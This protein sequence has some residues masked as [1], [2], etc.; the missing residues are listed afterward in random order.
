MP[1]AIRRR[2][3]SLWVHITMKK[4]IIRIG[5]VVVVLVLLAAAVVFFSLNSIVKK[6]VE[7]LG[8][9]MTKVEVRLGSAEISPFSGSGK[10]SKLFV[11]NPEGYKTPSAMEMGSIK[12]GVKVSSIMSDTIVV[13]EINIQAPDITLEG[14]LTGASNLKKILDNLDSS[15]AADEKQKN[16][17]PAAKKKEKKFIVKDLVIYGGKVN[18]SLDMS[19]LGSKSATVPLPPIHLQNIG[20]QSNGV[21]ASELARQIMQPLL[22]GVLDAAKNAATS[23]DMNLRG[24]GTNGAS[25]IN[26]GINDLFKKK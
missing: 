11:G 3:A 10:L 7:S 13:N 22:A 12:V 5:I 6:A 26:K 16:A 9:Q 17:A 21:T 8:P 25:Q 4:I 19:V 23:G 14:N 20:E 1:S 24:L 15:S 18:L 2:G